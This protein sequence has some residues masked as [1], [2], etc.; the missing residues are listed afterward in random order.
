MLII[1]I[2]V[3]TYIYTYIYNQN[4]EAVTNWAGPPSLCF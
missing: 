3:S 4:H 2:D 1:E